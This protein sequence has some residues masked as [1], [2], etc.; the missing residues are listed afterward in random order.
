MFLGLKQS[1]YF[2]NTALLYSDPD[3]SVPLDFPESGDDEDPVGLIDWPAGEGGAGAMGAVGTPGGGGIAAPAARRFTSTDFLAQFNGLLLKPVG[4][5]GAAAS[6]VA[7]ASG[8]GT[9]SD[10]SAQEEGQGVASA[11]AAKHGHGHSHAHGHAHAHGLG[12]SSLGSHSSPALNAQDPRGSGSGAAAAYGAPV[13]SGGPGLVVGGSVS[14]P[15][16]ETGDR[17]SGGGAS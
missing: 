6:G 13:V 9:R 10:A 17:L 4:G 15:G 14:Q 2:P 8:A 7:A 12:A 1:E 16:S 5:G 11:R 3:T